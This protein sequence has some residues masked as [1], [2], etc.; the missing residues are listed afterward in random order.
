MLIFGHEF[1]A[2]ARFYH[3]HSTESIALTPANSLLFIEFNIKN[4]DII[5]Y[6]QEND[7]DF[8]LEVTT[9][10]NALFCEHLNAKYIVCNDDIATRIQKC[11]EHYLFDAKILCRIND[12]SEIESIATQGIDGVLYPDAIIKV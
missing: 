11:A 10:K 1:L 4:L 7:L 8:A 3:I 9:L 12:D 6:M 5:T 2:S